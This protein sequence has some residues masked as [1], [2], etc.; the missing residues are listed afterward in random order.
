M[1]WICYLQFS[2]TKGNGNY[3]E[4]A[5]QNTQLKIMGSYLEKSLASNI[6]RFGKDA[7]IPRRCNRPQYIVRLA[8]NSG[9]N[10]SECLQQFSSHTSRFR[11]NLCSSFDC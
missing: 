1:V 5:N 6:Q 9:G 2:G 10:K 7:L 11:P 3:L 8:L 4:S